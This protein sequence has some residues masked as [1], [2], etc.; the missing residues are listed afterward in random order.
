M[1]SKMKIYIGLSTL[2]IITSLVIISFI[3]YFG[4][5]YAKTISDWGATG[6]FFGGIL[7]PILSFSTV[8][9]LI[10]PLRMQLK[11][12]SLTREEMTLNREEMT[13]TR[14]E[15]KKSRVSQESQQAVSYQ[16]LNEEK[17]NQLLKLIEKE[18]NKIEQCLNWQYTA[19]L[20]LGD[21]SESRLRTAIDSI[22]PSAKA[23][24]LKAN[25]LLLENAFINKVKL[26]TLFA[27][28]NDG[29][30][31]SYLVESVLDQLN[32]LFEV[33]HFFKG[34]ER[35]SWLVGALDGL[36]KHA[37]RSYYIRSIVNY[38]SLLSD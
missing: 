24:S 38:K 19:N 31:R 17:S 30:F 18:E 9:L 6:D 23:N 2:V 33:K 7:N 27:E 25:V 29:E 28:I 22:Q 34:S 13:L 16:L 21:L 20:K 1:N 4:I 35:S 26:V 14:E 5:G 32:Y 12:L 3:T 36:E 8:L 10:F 37:E 15:H 11:E